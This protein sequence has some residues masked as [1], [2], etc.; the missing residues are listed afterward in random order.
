MIIIFSFICF[1]LI[2]NCAI[3]LFSCCRPAGLPVSYR[4]SSRLSSVA[5]YNHYKILLEATISVGPDSIL[6]PGI[7]GPTDIESLNCIHGVFTR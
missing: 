5:G 1:R 3:N 7:P 4:N 6:C 2:H